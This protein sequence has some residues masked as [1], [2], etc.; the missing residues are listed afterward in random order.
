MGNLGP[1][2]LQI[3]LFPLGTLRELYSHYFSYT[4][5]WIV[6]IAVLKFS[7]LQWTKLTEFLTSWSWPIMSSVLCSTPGTCWTFL[8]WMWAERW[9]TR[10]RRVKSRGRVL[11]RG[12]QAQGPLGWKEVACLRHWEEKGGLWANYLGPSLSLLDDGTKFGF[13][14]KYNKNCRVLSR[15]A[16]SSHF[17]TIFQLL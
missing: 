2:F 17:K 11:G 8:R 10:S 16:Y 7:H 3:F 5:P 15:G 1:L 13:N 6:F 4:S 9:R 12:Q 14:C